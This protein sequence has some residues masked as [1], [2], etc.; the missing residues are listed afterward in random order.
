MIKRVIKFVDYL[1]RYLLDYLLKLTFV[2]SYIISRTGFFGKQIQ[3]A[4]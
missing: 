2:D 4:I 1:G 3:N